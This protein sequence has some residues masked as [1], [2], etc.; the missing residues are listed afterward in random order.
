[1]NEVGSG[2][3]L[4]FFVSHAGTDEDWATWIAQE[5]QNAGYTVELDVWNWAAGIDVIQATQRALD[6]ASR[7]L[8]VWTPDYFDRK[9]AGMEHRASFAAA[10]SE[11]GRLLPVMVRACPDEAIPLLYRTLKRVD[12]VGLTEP[13]A[14]ARLLD[15]VEGPSP[16]TSRLP[17]PGVT[18]RGSYPGTLPP[19]WNVP[20][21]NPFFTGREDS[22]R[23]LHE[24]LSATAATAIVDTDGEGGIGKSELAVE[25][26]WRHAA[27]Y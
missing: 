27:D 11:P 25:Y 2:E 10:Q 15:A 13:E 16:P 18:E 17:F 22:L 14:R 5:L 21:R 7:M 1:M 23:A 9:W 20:N 4:D 12:L 26:A 3:R 6:R 19:I 24:R 8:E